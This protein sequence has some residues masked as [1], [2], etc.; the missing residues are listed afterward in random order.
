MA[1]PT[2]WV[3]LAWLVVGFV[4]YAVYRRR[5]GLPLSATRR[6]PALVLGPS[7]TIEYRAYGVRAVA[8]LARGRTA[9]AAIVR[10]AE[11]RGAELIALG[12]RRRH[13]RGRTPIFGRTADYVIRTAPCRVLVAAGPRCG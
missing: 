11:L 13:A 5:L 12:A 10:E 7:L 4:G 8:R 2:R 9:G 6:A 3:G 1:A